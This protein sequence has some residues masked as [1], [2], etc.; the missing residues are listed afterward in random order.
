MS[1]YPH[2]LIDTDII[3]DH[4]T[5]SVNDESYLE[6]IMQIGICFT[7]VINACE[8]LFIAEDE[9][10]ENI[11]RTLNAFKILGVHQRYSLSIINKQKVDNLRDSLICTI[12][13]INK[14]GIVT[15]NRERY[16]NTGVNLLHPSE[17]LNK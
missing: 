6:R 3:I 7:T 16:I 8:L 15:F 4:L 12:A 5:H 14:L 11:I 17:V 13:K 1:K 9:E 10:N 2:F